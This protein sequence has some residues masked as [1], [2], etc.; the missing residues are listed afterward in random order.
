MAERKRSLEAAR[1]T[2]HLAVEDLASEFREAT[3]RLRVDAQALSF[4]VEEDEN[5][6]AARRMLLACHRMAKIQ[7]AFLRFCRLN[8]ADI[9]VRELSKGEHEAMVLEAWAEVRHANQDRMFTF[10]LEPLMPVRADRD[11][12][13]QV[14]QNLLSNAANYTAQR[15][16]SL[17]RVGCS[18]RWFLVEDNGIGFDMAWIDRLFGVFQRLHRES[19]FPG[20]GIGLATVRRIVERSGGGVAADG[21]PGLGATF[22]FRMEPVARPGAIGEGG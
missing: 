7:E 15:E 22:R 21:K 14:W 17:I 11:L 13:R 20:E 19:D 10:I 4:L 8:E 1:E 5:G 9:E 12:L 18:G 3:E 6:W 2:L 16:L